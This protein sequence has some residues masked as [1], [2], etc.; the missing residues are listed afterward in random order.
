[1]DGHER[2]V[3]HS[4]QFRLSAWLS[5]VIVAVALAAGAVSF[6]LAF[7]EAI[8]M[9]DGQLRQ[10]AALVAHRQIHP[11]RAI[12][13]RPVVDQEPEEKVIIR[14]LGQTAA[15]HP[16][17]SVTFP[18]DLPDGFRTIDAAGVSWRVFVREMDGAYRVAVAQQTSVRD[19]I[20]QASAL[21]T[22]LPLLLLV[23]ILLLVV[24]RMIRGMFV[25]LQTLSAELDRRSEHD[26][27]AIP[28]S[29][30][31]GEVRP[32][33]VAI[34]RLLA[35]SAQSMDM[36][37]RFLA[38][39]AHELRS[40]LTALSLQAEQLETAQMSPQAR[41]RLSSLRGGI[42][43]SRDLLEKLLTLAR[44]QDSAGG[45][46]EPVSI[47]QS[48]RQ[49]LADLVPLAD[50]KKID[51]GVIGD[52][53]ATVSIRE[54]DLD[55][56]IKNLIENAIRYTPE[57]GRIDISVGSRDGRPTLQVEDT[58]PGIPASDRERV[59]DPF[60]RILGS[61]EGGSGLG[62]SIVRAIAVRVGAQVTLSDVGGQA[63]SGLR[64]TVAF[65]P[66]P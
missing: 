63:G 60:F 55:T 11:D 48:I 61:A 44:V 53:D 35:K 50:I 5:A 32:F 46:V 49:V 7:N 10:I 56:L 6:L 40:P 2:K 37:R 25:P 8:E 59:F 20:A 23:P 4:L 14:F 34:N 16:N 52:G 42:L 57:G 28:G 39:A 47:Q 24:S 54:V 41:A 3:G 1:M 17:P 15:A 62:L 64:V 66:G 12:D 36:Q 18:A 26:L 45:Q 51:L 27:Y 65:A 31:I 58:G 33:V 29:H 38:D 43:R 13:A 21:Q 30:L 19:E 9:Q 22:V